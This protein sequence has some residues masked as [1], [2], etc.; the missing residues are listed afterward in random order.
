[1]KS[2]TTFRT[3]STKNFNTDSKDEVTLKSLVQVKSCNYGTHDSL[4]SKRTVVIFFNTCTLN[5]NKKLEEL[6]FLAVKCNILIICLQDHKICQLNTDKKQLQV[7]SEF[8]FLADSS[9]K[10]VLSTLASGLKILLLNKT[11]D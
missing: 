4:K 8:Y 3:I 6:Y 2:A 10:N 5:T 7:H 1:M 9:W 11:W